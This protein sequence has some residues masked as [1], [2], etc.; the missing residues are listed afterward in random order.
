MLANLL[1]LPFAN[2]A[3]AKDFLPSTDSEVLERLTPRVRMPTGTS[4]DVIATS[5]QAL[6][7]LSRETADPRYLGRAQS[8]LGTWWSN[9]AAPSSLAVLQATIEQSRHEF[10]AAMQ[11]LER[12][13]KTDPNNAQAW[14]TI[15]TIERVQANYP[16]ALQA[17]DQVARSGAKLYAA[18]CQFETLQLT[19]KANALAP[20]TTGLLDA[21]PTAATKAW[22]LSLSAEALERVG[23]DANALSHYKQSLALAADGYTSLALADLLLRTE[24]PSLALAALATQSDN[25]A[26]LLRRAV[27]HKRLNQPQWQAMRATLEARFAA[28][29]ARGEASVTHNANPST[30]GWHWPPRAP[31][32]TPPVSLR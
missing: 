3:N 8:A 18:A 10:A 28:L 31:A 13:V 1:V 17:C 14:L 21:M 9:P 12:A 4:V 16:K 32:L 7:A 29:Q 20:K 6:I 26:V 2:W 30:G 23:D 25:D 15:A 11:S 22:A 24:N 5:A 19:G 27:A